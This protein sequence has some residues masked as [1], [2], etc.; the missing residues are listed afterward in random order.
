MGLFANV[1]APM[2]CQYCGETTND[3]QTKSL[4]DLY[5]QTV[6]PAAIINGDF[7]GYCEHCRQYND[8]R[9]VPHGYSIV[10][11]DSTNNRGRNGA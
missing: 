10:A 2:P 1:D 5:M 3:W 9:V 4:E 6:K 11:A 8:W 7:Y